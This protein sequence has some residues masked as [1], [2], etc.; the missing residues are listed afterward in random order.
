M[1]QEKQRFTYLWNAFNNNTATEA[2]TKELLSL[3]SSEEESTIDQLMEEAAA[4]YLLQ[5]AT[6]AL[7]TWKAM[8]QRLLHKEASKAKSITKKIWFWRGAAAAALAG[9]VTYMLTLSPPRSVTLT[10]QE[11]DRYVTL[12]DGSVVILQKGSSLRYNKEFGKLRRNLQLT[13][14]AW[15]NVATDP[16]KPF[17][18][19]TSNLT[20]TVL[21]TTFSITALPNS[22]QVS[23][24]VTSGKVKVERGTK[25]LRILAASEG[26]EASIE[27][28]QYTAWHTSAD[29]AN[30]WMNTDLNFNNVPY[31]DIA[32]RLSARF[33][34]SIQFTS[35]A[36][37]A[38][39]VATQLSG[40]A[41]LT[42][43]LDIL[44]PATGTT[45]H[46]HDKQVVISKK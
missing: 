27:G 2:E 35:P 3:L 43:M 5:S 10:A 36:A 12:G 9:V 18:V 30:R 23:V 22:G 17:T 29:S 15:F 46:I 20:T 33:G 21:G 41:T 7:P 40:S 11:N 1:Q 32:T 4:P 44:S 39:K 37:A 38:I 26:L 6:P 19:Q 13:G 14:Q 45:Y 28:A 31:R 34:V 8:E 42:Q 25:V 16:G 24:N